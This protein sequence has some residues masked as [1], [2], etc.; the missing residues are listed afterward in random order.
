MFRKKIHRKPHKKGDRKL[1][2]TIEKNF[3]PVL[4][5][6]KLNTVQGRK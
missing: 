6:E 2:R 5:L 3:L 4:I 1:N